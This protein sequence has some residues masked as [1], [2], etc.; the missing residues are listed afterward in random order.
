MKHKLSAIAIGCITGLLANTVLAASGGIVG[1]LTDNSDSLVI[2]GAIVKIK[3]LNLSTVTKNDGFFRF[4]DLDDGVYTLEV[5]YVGADPVTKT[6]AITNGAIVRQN[7][8]LGEDSI[9]NIIVLGQRS[10][11]AQALNIKRSA[12]NL[13]SIVSADAIGQFPDQNAAEALQRL[14]GL[15]IERDQGEGRFVSI[16]GIDPNLNNVTINGL[17]VPSPEAGVRSVA[18]DVIPSELVEGLVVTKS[19]TSDLD[20]DAIGGSVE[21]KSLSAFD[22]QGISANFTAQASYNELEDETSPRLSGS[23]TNV[24]DFAGHNDALGVA[25]AISYFDRDFGSDN[26]ESNGDDELE[27]RDYIINRERLGAA[28]NFDFRPNIDNQYYLRTLY[29][30]FSDD[31]YRLSNTFTFDGDDSEVERATRDRFEEQEILSITAGGEHYLANQWHI[32]YQLGYSESSEDQPNAL[33]YA[34][35]VEDVDISTDFIGPI[36]TINQSARSLDL[37]NYELDEIELNSGLTED[38]EITFRFDVSKDFDWAGNP[39]QIKFG[40]K[41]RDREKFN[42]ADVLF[43][44]GDFDGIDPSQFA[45]ATPDYGL[46][47]FGPGISRSGLQRF[48]NEQRNEFEVEPLE[49]QLESDGESYTS[50]EDIFAAYILGK[51]DRGPLRVVAGLRY[52]GTDFL[53]SG[54]I[55]EQIEDEQADLETVLATPVLVERD[56]SHVLPSLNIRYEFS[57]NLIGR[58]AYTQ[59]ISRPRFEDSAAFQL[60]ESSTEENDEGEFETE[61]EGEIGNPQLEAAESDNIDIAIE[62]YPG[63]I[64][65]LSAGY[66][67]KDIDN[68]VVFA[69]VAD[70]VEGFDELIQPINGESAEVQGVELS[71]VKGFDNGFLIAANATFSDSDAVTFLDGERFDTS[72]PNQSDTIGN[73]T[74]A[75]ENSKLSLRL[76]WVHKGDNFEEIDD[77]LLLFEDDHNQIDFR[78]KYFVNDHFQLFFNAININ[79]EPFYNFFDERQNNAQFEEYGSTFEL[80]FSWKL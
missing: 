27:Q 32:S 18:L 28:L 57:E 63:K 56:Y 69:D 67:R 20:A 2:E 14:P 23:V 6:I 53:T 25:A 15:S 80:G 45:V 42:R 40:S 61:R 7:V 49:S 22:R 31:E 78:A 72:L 47:N 66:F 62:Y 36:P 3:E 60:I 68:F 29:S 17:N 33:Q 1:K 64:G 79:D 34:F 16:R 9:E 73:L 10:G 4:S 26:I 5:S 54:S 35:V 65:V 21:V 24:F 70:S 71:W 11:Q 75:Y 30:R 39:A 8:S 46:G 74:L 41:Y 76:T 38:E 19:I 43:F 52:E 55:V 13:Q 58:F 51:V 48:F 59:T 50:E 77:D 12:D 44:D 37:A